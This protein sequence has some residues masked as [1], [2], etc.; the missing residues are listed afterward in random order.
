MLR[1]T[2]IYSVALFLISCN[3]EIKFK[4][5]DVLYLDFNKKTPVLEKTSF[6][7]TR[8][9]DNI[10]D[11]IKIERSKTDTF[12]NT[13]GYS[14]D[15]YKQVIKHV[16]SST[17]DSFKI[18][19]TIN[20]AIDSM[21]KFELN[22]TYLEPISRE[23]KHYYYLPENKLYQFPFRNTNGFYKYTQNAGLTLI[24]FGNN[25]IYKQI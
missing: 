24:S 2:L 8:M 7:Y 13:V 14:S 25:L 21:I 17:D 18:I 4:D 23:I 6:D 20:A 15:N 5:Y 1:K 22:D 9:H 3:D 19:I 12:F 11:T 16:Y 10:I